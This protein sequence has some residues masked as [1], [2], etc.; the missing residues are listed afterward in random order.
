MTGAQL[1]ERWIAKQREGVGYL[2][3]TV[4]GFAAELEVSR[5]T[6]NCWVRGEKTPTEA[7]AKKLAAI[8][9]NAVPAKAW[10]VEEA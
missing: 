7:N 8:T 10:R 2:R 6:V 9:K 4:T 1:L 5:D 3:F